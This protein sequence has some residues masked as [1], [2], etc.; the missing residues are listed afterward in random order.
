M[1]D[2]QREVLWLL[3][4]ICANSG[5]GSNIDH[6]I[7]AE[8]YRNG[9]TTLYHEPL[10][11]EMSED[12]QNETEEILDMFDHVERAC[13]QLNVNQDLRENLSFQGFC[14]NECTH[15]M[16]ARIIEMQG[17]FNYLS[18]PLHT[19][20]HSSATIE[21][22]RRMLRRWNLSTDRY[23]LTLDDLNEI[24]DSRRYPHP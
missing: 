1:D 21:I 15:S 8:V 13:Q 6:N 2:F 7:M 23:N 18:H 17:R 3:H 14:G 16:F 4:T 24:N 19:N 10:S 5:F 11:E 9:F 20:S 12:I 22:Y